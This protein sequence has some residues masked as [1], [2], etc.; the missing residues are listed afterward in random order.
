M[1]LNFKVIKKVAPLPP[2]MSISTSPFQGYSPFLAT[3]LVL[4]QAT[5]FLEGPIPPFNKGGGGP[6]NS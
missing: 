3:F 5:Q 4:P 1:Q 6:T 2:S